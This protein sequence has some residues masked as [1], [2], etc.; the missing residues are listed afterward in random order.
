VINSVRKNVISMRTREGTGRLLPYVMPHKRLI[1]RAVVF[2]SV[3]TAFNLLVPWITGTV[4]IDEVIV[5][6]NLTLLPWVVVGLLGF[7]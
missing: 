6:Q 5:K 2:M 1:A 3:A 4:L 7:G